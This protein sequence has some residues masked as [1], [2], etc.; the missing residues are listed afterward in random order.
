M[1]IRA[2][3]VLAGAVFWTA[4]I[5]DDYEGTYRGQNNYWDASVD[6][7]LRDGKAT[8]RTIKDG[9]TRS[10]NGTYRRNVLSF[11]GA[12]YSMQLEKSGIWLTQKGVGKN[13]AF[14]TR[15]GSHENKDD[16][17]SDPQLV[18]TYSGFNSTWNQKWHLTLYRD[19]RAA[20]KVYSDG[21]EA[22]ELGGSWTRRQG[23]LD[24]GLQHYRMNRRGNTL[25][26][27]NETRAS[28]TFT[29]TRTNGKGDVTPITTTPEWLVG[30]FRGFA[31]YS[32]SDVVLTVRSGGNA[33]L[34]MT[35][36]R[37]VNRYE[38]TY[39]NGRILLENGNQWLVARSNGG[40]TITNSKDSSQRISLS[41]R[42]SIYDKPPTGLV[43]TF[44]GRHWDGYAVTL[45]IHQDGNATMSTGNRSRV[46]GGYR[47][48]VLRL[49][50]REYTITAKSNGVRIWEVGTQD[51][52]DLTR[53]NR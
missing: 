32:G 35:R 2:L 27:E 42:D 46:S 30:T 19:G 39:R 18:G 7:T 24:L 12:Q 14:Y 29:L 5:A 47:N 44:T 1:S 9:R 33:V 43:G 3:L 8:I 48:G 25:Y 45:S 38:G 21:G 17:K 49:G 16:I 52:A 41:E 34:E 15:V 31:R 20:A 51:R 36:N 13:R 23:M 22:Q 11:G 6:L 53:L 10:E 4:A 40:I 26:L 28:D 50:G 37:N